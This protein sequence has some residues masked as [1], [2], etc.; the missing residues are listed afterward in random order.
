MRG[1]A[2]AGKVCLA[3]CAV[4]TNLSVSRSKT[5]ADMLSKLIGMKLLLVLASSEAKAGK[6]K[7][8]GAREKIV[9]T[10]VAQEPVALTRGLSPLKENDGT[11]G[12]VNANTRPM[13]MQRAKRNQTRTRR[14]KY[15]PHRPRSFLYHWPQKCRRTAFLRS[16]F[17][18]LVIWCSS[19]LA[20]SAPIAGT[21]T[22]ST[23]PSGERTSSLTMGPVVGV[24]GNWLYPELVTGPAP[25]AEL[26]RGPWLL[27]SAKMS[28]ASPPASFSS[29]IPPLTGS[30]RPVLKNEPRL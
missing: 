8:A 19:S 18:V 12:I 25:K 11:R 5:W 9:G 4:P 22:I 20:H 27:K 14:V 7:L 21:V 3:I 1:K 30:S 2:L 26:Y 13:A 23:F 29:S 15:F 17:P 16:R 10:A 24:G 6:E 28:Q